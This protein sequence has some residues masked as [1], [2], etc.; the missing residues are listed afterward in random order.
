MNTILETDYLIIGSG[1]VGM[2]FA[3]TLLTETNATITIV[4]KLDKPGGHWNF[5]YPFVKLHQPSAY[6][7]VN[8]M[9]LSKGRVDKVGFNK[10]LNELAT[11]PE[12]LA[13]FN[14]VMQHK[15]L[16]SDR[17]NYFPLCE[18][19][20]SGIFKATLTGKTF[21]VK[22]KKKTVDAT[23]LKTV[24]PATHTP[25]FEIA[26]GVRFMPLNNLPKINKKPSGFVVIGGG[27]TAMD[28]CLWLLE[29]NIDPDLITWIVPR[30]AWLLNRKNYQLD[31][32]HF[33][34]FLEDQAIQFES[35]ALADSIPDL[36]DRL[37]RG[38]SLLRIDKKVLPTMYRCATVSQEELEQLSRIKHIIRKGRVKR[39]EQNQIVLEKGTIKTSPENI[40]IDCS[41]SGLSY[42]ELKPVFAGNLIT[43]QTVRTC[44]P[45]FSGA[46]IAH[47]EATYKDEA[48]KNELCTV[49]PVPHRD[50]DWIRM[51][52]VR[53][54]NQFNWNNNEE[55]FKWLQN[56]R[57]EGGFAGKFA[58]IPKDNEKQQALLERIRKNIE[59]AIA[60][61]QLFL[62]QLS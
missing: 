48:L 19:Q 29:H 44:Q 43:I 23:H 33:E 8:S 52:A 24:I 31:N 6:Y 61:L 50:I 22:V 25:S 59:P 60:K 18:Y 20:G 30:D 34:Y 46:F 56:S 40:H 55:V 16:P 14:E 62:K 35:L 51:M 36:F 9:G 4:D 12:V 32:A 2:A 7:G 58:A 17:V 10:G 54:K 42:P 28:A 38:G 39:I 57:L 49:I 3:D 53:M 1:A 5:A 15:F 11:G 26:S 41:A 27:K 45:T 21:E 37:E 13:Y 47:I